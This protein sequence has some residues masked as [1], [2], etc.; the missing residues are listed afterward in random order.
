MRSVSEAMSFTYTLRARQHAVESFTSTTESGVVADRLRLFRS[1]AV[2]LSTAVTI[3]RYCET[4]PNEMLSDPPHGDTTALLGP[5]VRIP[6][7]NGAHSHEAV[8][9]NSV[10]H[11]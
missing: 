5:A 1:L 9:A 3:A 11:R 4:I 10:T 2:V 6:P 7:K 8:P